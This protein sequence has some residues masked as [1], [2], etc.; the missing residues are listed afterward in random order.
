M[1]SFSKRVQNFAMEIIRYKWTFNVC[2]EKK[3]CQICEMGP[4][5]F[6]NQVALFRNTLYNTMNESVPNYIFQ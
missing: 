1:V 6:F 2:L 4:N 3:Y 5:I